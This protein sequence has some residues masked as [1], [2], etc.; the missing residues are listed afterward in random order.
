MIW[1]KAHYSFIFHPT[2]DVSK[3]F[4]TLPYFTPILGNSNYAMFSLVACKYRRN[5]AVAFYGCKLMRSVLPGGFAQLC[6][7]PR[8][9]TTC[10]RLKLPWS[11]PPDLKYVWP[12]SNIVCNQISESS[13]RSVGHHLNSRCGETQKAQFGNWLI[14]SQCQHKKNPAWL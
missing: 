13:A 1:F 6:P 12:V 7:T 5:F 8:M 3:F 9:S 11:A 4:C 10:G 2:W 14:K